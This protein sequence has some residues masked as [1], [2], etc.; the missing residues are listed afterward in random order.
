MVHTGNIRNNEKNYNNYPGRYRRHSLDVVSGN[1]DLQP[2]RGEE[3]RRN[4][5]I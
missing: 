5:T 2:I 4:P 1:K 3:L